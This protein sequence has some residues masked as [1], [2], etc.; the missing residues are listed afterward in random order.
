MAQNAEF[1]MHARAIRRKKLQTISKIHHVA[2]LLG[3][4]MTLSW[5][6]PM[7]APAQ[8]SQWWQPY[9]DDAYTMG[10]WHFDD[11]T[12]LSTSFAD[13][14]SANPGRD[15]NGTRPAWSTVVIEPSG[16]GTDSGTGL[17]GKALQGFSYSSTH[18]IADDN[19]DMEYSGDFTIE[20]WIRPSASD[21]TGK[22][23]IASKG[24]TSNG[25]S[26][27]LADGK[28]YF[29]I[30]TFQNN[31]VVGDTTLA[32]NTWHHI[33]AALD[34]NQNGGWQ[35]HVRFYVN[36]VLDGDRYNPPDGDSV[37]NDYN[38]IIGCGEP[39]NLWDFSGVID[40]VR[41]SSVA[42]EFAPILDCN[43]NPGCN[44]V[45]AED[46]LFGLVEND[47]TPGT[48]ALG[49]WTGQNSPTCRTVIL[50]SS[51]NSVGVDLGVSTIVT[52][53]KVVSWDMMLSEDGN[54]GSRWETHLNGSNTELYYSSNNVTY[55]KVPSSQFT[56]YLDSDTR[57]GSLPFRQFHFTGLDIEARYI[58]VHCTLAT[59]DWSWISY[60]DR[61]IIVDGPGITGNWFPPM[62]DPQP[63]VYPW[64]ADCLPFGSTGDSGIGGMCG[65]SGV[66]C[67]SATYHPRLLPQMLTKL[68]QARAL[69]TK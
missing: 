35:D 18:Q 13:D 64:A 50:D 56:I 6:L 55:T 2:L 32:A 10:L 59:A 68:R 34:N 54:P 39:S 25:W 22:H 3:L 48:S 4:V 65:S 5:C 61:A 14:D 33:A 30:R 45:D 29:Q 24:W 31:S 63:R 40:E 16:A 7:A 58:K 62:A 66:S 26:F 46:V 9:S 53:V 52:S 11:V 8:Q 12:D 21:L 19:S 57:M 42:R 20:A 44:P 47:S 60:L 38:L 1:S 23:G 41:Y 69:W 43:D 28:L 15:N 49:N 51:Q 17:F 67:T 27:G 37:H 36:G